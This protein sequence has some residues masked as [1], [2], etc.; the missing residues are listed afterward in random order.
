MEYPMVMNEIP[1]N[2]WK[3]PKR[4]GVSL[5][6]LLLV[7]AFLLNFFLANAVTRL[8]NGALTKALVPEAHIETISIRLL[9]GLVQVEGLSIVQPEGFGKGAFLDLGKVWINF[10]WLSLLSG[11]VYFSHV[12][13]DSLSVTI[14]KDTNG[15]MNIARLTPME[16]TSPAP[17]GEPSA[18]PE[19]KDTPPEK[20]SSK[21]P[22]AVRVGK[23]T[24]ERL[25]LTYLDQSASAEKPVEILLRQAEIAIHDLLFDPAQATRQDLTAEL[26]FTGQ[27]EHQDTP[28]AFIGLTARLG[29][30][31]TDIPALVAALVISGAELGA[32]GSVV[33]PGVA[34][35]V[36]GDV[37]DLGANIRLA[38]ELLDVQ[39]EIISAGARF[40]IAVGGTPAS[41]Q[42]EAG[43][44][45]LGAFGRIGGLVGNSIGNVADAGLQVGAGAV[46]VAAS[47]GKG[48]GS[49]VTGVGKGLFNAAKSAAT[50]DVQG[51]GEGLNASA[52][53]AVQGARE[54]VVEA[55]ATTVETIGEAG[56]VSSGRADAQQWREEK[57]QRFNQSWETAQAWVR[58]AAYPRPSAP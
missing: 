57:K 2:R 55:G 17:S 12:G 50:L 49:I 35:T 9:R 56:Q 41:P 8:A 45:L 5:L 34:A 28:P 15:V 10:R 27:L 1:K 46:N 44:I 38:P 23:I 48:A 47:V 54:T 30:L 36:G 58:E 31:S 32:A 24:V 25:A 43:A 29:P 52:T 6:V 40:P 7:L 37:I 22:T 19:S 16:A 53:S 14:V 3:W 11:P 39:A 42:V 13:V 26:T 20:E 21:P 51:I 18:I 4:I 33:P